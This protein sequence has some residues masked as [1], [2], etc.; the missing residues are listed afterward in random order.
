MFTRKLTKKQQTFIDYWLN[1]PRA[2]ATEAALFAYNTDNPVVAAS[3]AY[4][5]FRKPQIIMALGDYGELFE[6]TIVQTVRDWKDAEAPRKREI[7][8]NA[9][10]YAY[11]HIHGRSIVR[12]EQQTSLVKIAID[13]SGGDQLPPPAMV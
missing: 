8:L 2:S 3:I 5:N 13:L 7:A 12:V 4:E 11:D 10:K 6:G 1:H 9:S